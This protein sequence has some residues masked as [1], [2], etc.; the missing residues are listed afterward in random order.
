MIMVLNCPVHCPIPFDVIHNKVL[1]A[2]EGKPRDDRVGDDVRDLD[3][4]PMAARRDL[5][6][7]RGRT[8]QLHTLGHPDEREEQFP[9]VPTSVLRGLENWDAI[10]LHVRKAIEKLLD[11]E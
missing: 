10:P 2:V 7:I 5:V 1:I 11:V 4:W 8:P 6:Q 3:R 9:I